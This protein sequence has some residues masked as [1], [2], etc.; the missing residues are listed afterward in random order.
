M[1]SNYKFY[2]VSSRF[3]IVK[4]TSQKEKLIGGTF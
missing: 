1:F 4:S 3:Y 2:K